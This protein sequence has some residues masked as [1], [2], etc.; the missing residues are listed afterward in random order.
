MVPF[1]I[2]C[3]KLWALLENVLRHFGLRTHCTYL[4]LES[5]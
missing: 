5:L 4:L 1:D 3:I 2:T